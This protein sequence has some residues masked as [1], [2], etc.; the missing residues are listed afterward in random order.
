MGS[1]AGLVVAAVVAVV[2]GVV[3]TA[4]ISS[5]VVKDSAEAAAAADGQ[6]KNQPAGYGAR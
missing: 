2:L 5:V 4:T 6:E 3:G 1:V